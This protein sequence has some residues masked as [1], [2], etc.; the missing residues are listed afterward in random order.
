VTFVDYARITATP[1][2]RW[3][4]FIHQLNAYRLLSR[5]L[6]HDMSL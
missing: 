1:Q 4:M 5:R 3:M 6:F 2:R